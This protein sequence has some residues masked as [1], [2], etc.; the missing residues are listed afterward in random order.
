MRVSS[1][2]SKLNYSVTSHHSS[3][4]PSTINLS[5]PLGPRVVL[6]AS[7]ITWPKK[8]TTLN[9]Q[10]NYVEKQ[11]ASNKIKVC[12]A[13]L[14]GIDVTDELRDALGGVC[15]LLQHDNRCGLEK[16]ESQG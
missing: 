13:H 12:F 8:K 15:P 5:I 3:P 4:L 10:K 2:E 9:L 1:F 14:A 11:Q 16:D 6:T 7:A